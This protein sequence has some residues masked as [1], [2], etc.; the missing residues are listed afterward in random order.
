MPAVLFVFRAF[1]L[2]S[3]RSELWRVLQPTLFF[4]TLS[5]SIALPA[6]IAGS[7]GYW[8]FDDGNG[9]TA[10]DFARNG[11][12]G[13]KDP[14]TTGIHYVQVA[15]SDSLGLKSELT[16]A[17]SHINS[18]SNLT[19]ESIP[20]NLV[21]PTIMPNGGSYTGPLSVS[22]QSAVSGASI[23]FTTDGS[24]PTQSSTLYTGVINLTKSTIVKA[25]A[26]KSGYIPSAETSASFAVLPVS[27]F[28]CNFYASPTGTGNGLSPSSPFK[29]INFWSVAAPGKTLCLLDGIYTGDHSM[30]DPPDNLSGT[31]G[32]PI[33]VR[34]LNDGKVTINGQGVRRPVLL[35]LNNYFVLEGFNA[36]SSNEGVVRVVR[37]SHNVIRRVAAWDAHEGNFSVVSAG[38][39]QHI[40]FEDVAAWGIGR[41]VFS[42]SQG[43]NYVTCRRCWGRWEGSHF[44]GPKLTYSLAYNNYD[45]IIENSIGTWSGEKMRE[46][47]VL[48]CPS[49]TNY[50]K[51]GQSMTGYTVDQAEAIFGIDRLDGDKNARSKIFGSIAYITKKDRYHPGKLY[52]VTA[53]NAIEYG[54]NI[55]YIE[56]GTYGG[57]RAFSLDIGQNL[58]AR[59]LTAIAAT[60]SYFHSAWQL[61]S[62]SEASTVAAASNPFTG[63]NGA[64]ICKRYKDGVLTSQPLWPWPMNQRIGEAMISSGKVAVDVTRT[65]EGIFGPIPSQCRN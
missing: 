15:H 48:Q 60:P 21:A 11:N 19:V 1:P 31:A 9:A 52:W 61:S 13:I 30:I 2:S 6:S 23:Y 18:P 35:N 33:T 12:T 54:N 49:G 36:H 39:G 64:Q 34:A 63:T 22:L 8:N 46:N 4:V 5:L 7:I 25:R 29:I 28:S 47:Y 58:I 42:A 50:S 10:A 62:V 56:P 43:G 16:V 55:A 57:K 37:S 41:K 40:L 14:W 32:G 24:S 3:R 51:C 44:V 26:F 20:P 45:M 65:I 53:M 38:S 59:N 27:T 17:A